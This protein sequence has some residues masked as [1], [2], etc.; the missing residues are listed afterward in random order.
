MTQSNRLK[1]LTL[2]AMLLALCII[3]AN[4]K[5]MGS[6]AFDSAPAFLGA[7]LLGPGFGATL[8]VFGHL[9]SAALAG[10]PL[11]LPI[12]L[13][14]AFAMGVCM[15]VFGLIRNWLGKDRLTGVLISDVLGYAINVPIEL[16]LLYPLMKQAIFAFFVPL[17]IATV[18]NLIVCEVIYVALPHRV[19]DA[20]FLVS[21]K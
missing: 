8:G 12:H 21:Q 20:P 9:V 13:I 18:L 3:G 5:I 16:V 10:F 19:K 17:T 2:A 15:F 6:V 7:V 4:I 1:K 14:I 11:T